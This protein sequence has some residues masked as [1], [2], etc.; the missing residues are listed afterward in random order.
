MIKRMSSTLKNI[1]FMAGTGRDRMKLRSPTSSIMTFLMAL[2]ISNALVVMCSTL[3]IMR[4]MKMI[5]YLFLSDL[6]VKHKAYQR[7]N[8][9]YRKGQT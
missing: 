1:S 6:A 3:L 7:E 9:S 2:M 5:F 4:M 8:N